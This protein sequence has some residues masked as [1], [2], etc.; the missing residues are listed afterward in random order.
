MSE[1]NSLDVL[2]HAVNRY[3]VLSAILTSSR[4]LC[5][6]AR[7]SL[8]HIEHAILRGRVRPDCYSAASI[9]MEYGAACTRNG[10][11]GD[12]TYAMKLA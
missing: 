6:S 7:S 3:M 8:A 4:L 10:D 12:V 2:N 11:G 1:A 5:G 9:V